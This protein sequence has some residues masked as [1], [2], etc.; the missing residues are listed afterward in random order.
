MIVAILTRKAVFAI[1]S[2]TLLYRLLVLQE[3][4]CTHKSFHST[5]FRYIPTQLR[6]RLKYEACRCDEVRL[7]NAVSSTCAGPWLGNIHQTSSWHSKPPYH[8]SEQYVQEAFS[9]PR[10]NLTQHIL[11]DINWSSSACHV[12]RTPIH[13]PS[14]SSNAFIRCSKPPVNRS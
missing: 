10:A 6:H 1:R 7:E 13:Y 8:L 11:T 4:K 12:W 3:G 5:R 9:R 2:V 14:L